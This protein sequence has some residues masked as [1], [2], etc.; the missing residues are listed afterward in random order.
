MPLAVIR[1]TSDWDRI[2]EKLLAAAQAGQGVP[3]VE[4]ETP[5]LHA[6]GWGRQVCR[7]MQHAEAQVRAEAAHLRFSETEAGA[8]RMAQMLPGCTSLPAFTPV[9][10]TEVSSPPQNVVACPAMAVVSVTEGVGTFAN[11]T[12]TV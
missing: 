2:D 9:Q 5:A 10:G 6:P 11:D 3:S 1:T 8:R 7:S 4:V 12:H